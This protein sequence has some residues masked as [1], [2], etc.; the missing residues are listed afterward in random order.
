MGVTVLGCTLSSV[1]HHGSSSTQK[2][3]YAQCT[4]WFGFSRSAAQCGA[5]FAVSEARRPLKKS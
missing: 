5:V 2:H 1:V 3:R 4:D